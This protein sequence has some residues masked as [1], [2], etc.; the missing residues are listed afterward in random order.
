[1]LRARSGLPGEHRGRL[2]EGPGRQPW[3]SRRFQQALLSSQSSFQMRISLKVLRV[4]SAHRLSQIVDT[5]DGRQTLDRQG[6]TRPFS[7]FSQQLS[8]MK[9]VSELFSIDSRLPYSI[10]K[11]RKLFIVV[12]LQR[13][14]VVVF[15]GYTV[16]SKFAWTD[17]NVLYVFIK[18]ESRIWDPKG[19]IYI[20]I[21]IY[22]YI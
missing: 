22:I 17:G 10:K 14:C 5:N 11:S 21:Y 18:I 9:T 19:N 2:L 7:V 20:Y 8:E 16:I 6:M 13:L 12:S 3:A 1:M 4:S 15:Y